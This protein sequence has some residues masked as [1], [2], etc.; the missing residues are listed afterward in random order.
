MLI[1]DDVQFL[2]GKSIQQEFCHTL[3]AL[4]D[5]GV[6]WSYGGP[7]ASEL[8]TLD[9]RVLSRFKGGLC[10]DIGQLDEG[11][12]VKF[13]RRASPRREKGNLVFW[14]RPK[15]S[16]MW[17]RPLRPMAATRG[18]RESVA[19]AFALDGAPLCARDGGNR[20]TRPCAHAR[21]QARKDRRY[22]EARGRH[23]NIFG[24]ISVGSPHDNVVRPR[25]I[26]MYLSKTLTLARCRN[27]AALWRPRSYDRSARGAKDRGFRLEGP[28]PRRSHRVAEA[29]ALRAVI[30]HGSGFVT[31]FGAWHRA[32]LMAS[33]EWWGCS[34]L[35][36]TGVT[37]G[38]RATPSKPEQGLN[39]QELANSPFQDKRIVEKCD[40]AVLAGSRGDH[41]SHRHRRQ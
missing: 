27:R 3:N 32:I 41:L 25:Q 26:A 7:P 28:R 33:G 13:W 36:G 22:S 29:H 16:H 1:I 23:F 31:L 34:S 40:F 35:R 17:P 15:L 12:R 9:E 38:S 24:P 10:I 14:C 21:P 11:L 18:S 20:D 39:R 8:E 19:R 37:S 4:I 6:R 30:R 2:H 5:S